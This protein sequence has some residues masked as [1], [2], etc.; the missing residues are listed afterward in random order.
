MQPNA[1]PTH[2]NQRKKDE[3]TLRL[4]A[5]FQ[6]LFVTFLWSTSWVLIKIGLKDIP[7]LTFA[8]LRY[9]LAFVCLLPFALQ[10]G[11]RAGLK[12]LARRDWLSLAALG[13]LYYTITQGAQYLGLLYLPATS[14]SLVLNFTSA[15]VALMGVFILHEY[16]TRLQWAGVLLFL[17]GIAVYFYPLA[18][19]PGQVTG[20][21]I[22]LLGVFTNAVSV[23]LG[24]RINRERR[25]TPLNVTAVSMGIGGLA[26]LAVGLI[27]HPLP[28]LSLQSWLI[29]AWLALVN[30]AF[31]FTLWNHTL[32][33]LSAV[34]SSIINSTMLVQI[35]ILAWI[36]LGESLGGRQIVGV[37][38]VSLAVFVV[39]LK[40]RG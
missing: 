35:A 40:N 23:L 16:P 17:A 38:L 22:V 36:F 29:I 28:A 21:L 37:V 12:R 33:T 20:I 19:P 1:I 3:R 11:Q 4:E 30:T 31:A 9:S 5:V 32:R 26:L 8:G 39:Q 13:L 6:A 10:P 18:I 27:T 14:V 34:E 15:L 7:A 24:R 2:P 25:L